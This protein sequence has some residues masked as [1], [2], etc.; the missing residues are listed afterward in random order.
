M[1]DIWL[2]SQ[3]QDVETLGC[4]SFVSMLA[5]SNPIVN[6]ELLLLNLDLRLGYVW[7]VICELSVVYIEA[8]LLGFSIFH[9]PTDYLLYN[10]ADVHW[11][12]LIYSG[13]LGLM[14]IS[15]WYF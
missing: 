7:S 15:T 14:K 5:S 6:C 8:D 3:L 10:K 9:I 1:D 13:F 11:F 12:S 4:V 2:D